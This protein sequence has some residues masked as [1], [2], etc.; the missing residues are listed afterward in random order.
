MKR[1]IAEQSDKCGICQEQFTDY[2]DELRS[3]LKMGRCSEPMRRA[4]WL[5]KFE[6]GVV[7]GLRDST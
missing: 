6:S 2:N 3:V 5:A 4:A 1:K 7:S